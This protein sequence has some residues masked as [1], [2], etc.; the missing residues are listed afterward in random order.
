MDSGYFG[1]AS[2]P[3]DSPFSTCKKSKPKIAFII[4]SPSTIEASHLGLM[5]QIEHIPN[6]H[7]PVGNMH[8]I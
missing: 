7:L 2:L 6:K 1:S 3:C 8:A 4:L 5:R